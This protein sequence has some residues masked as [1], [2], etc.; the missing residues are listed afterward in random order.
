MNP[1]ILPRTKIELVYVNCQ[2]KADVGTSVFYDAAVFGK[3]DLVPDLD[4]VLFFPKIVDDLGVR[5]I[6]LYTHRAGLKI[7]CECEPFLGRAAIH[8]YLPLPSL[9]FY[10]R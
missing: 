3:M 4:E 6:I 1:N 7:D 10:A 8:A 2:C 9:S 5:Y